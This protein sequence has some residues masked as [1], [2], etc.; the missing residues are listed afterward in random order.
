MN[1]QA[2]YDVLHRRVFQLLGDGS[3]GDQYVYDSLG[4]LV[5]DSVM[6]APTGNSCP[7]HPIIGQD[8][9][10]CVANMSWTAQS[11]TGFAYDAVGN[12]LDNGGAYGA[13]D[14]ITAF[15]ACSYGTDADGDVVSRT[16]GT[17]GVTFKWTSD[18][19][20]DTLMVGSTTIVY[21]YD[22]SGRLVRKDVNGTPQSYFLWDGANLLAELNGTGTAAVAEYSYYG[23]D[24]LHA[25]VVG[26]HVYYAHT[27][28]LGNVVALTDSMAQVKRSY[29]YDAWGALTGGTDNLP[30]SNADRARWKGALWLGP[31][32][33]LYYVRN[34]WYEPQSGRFLSEDPAGLAGGLNPYLYAGDDPIDG[35]D[36]SGLNPACLESPGLFGHCGT[37]TSGVGG[38]V[39]YD[40]RALDDPLWDNFVRLS[41]QSAYGPTG[42]GCIGNASCTPDP[43][44][45]AA[46]YAAALAMSP[47]SSSTLVATAFG[48]DRADFKGFPKEVPVKR[49]VLYFDQN[50]ELYTG[51]I[52]GRFTLVPGE[53]TWFAPEYSFTGT[54]DGV[55]ASGFLVI[56]RFYFFF[57]VISDIPW[58]RLP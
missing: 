39:E 54:F 34:R 11:G 5:A 37:N 25:L 55:E 35:S 58:P 16:C 21:W 19:R 56:N 28:V 26:G 6:T 1:R 31:E 38:D 53:G 32:V 51:F 24:R 20:L 30:F 50:G 12:R 52:D 22:A 4:R 17:Q 44:Y 43:G 13:G 33:D 23:V 46:V 29:N 14:R 45:V 2:Q 18:G 41:G 36:P 27:D 40:P 47:A 57:A 42:L 3:T 15:A 8:G 10:D 7:G 9:S 48:W 49:D